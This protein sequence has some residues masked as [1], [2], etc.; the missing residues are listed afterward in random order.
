MY[1]CFNNY[2]ETGVRLILLCV[3][4]YFKNSTTFLPSPSI[5][6]SSNP[7]PSFRMPLYLST[8][9]IPYIP[10]A[11]WKPTFPSGTL[12]PNHHRSFAFR[13]TIFSCSIYL[14]HLPIPFHF[15]L[16]GF[17]FRIIP[18]C[19]FNIPIS[20]FHFLKKDFDFS[21]SNI[22]FFKTKKPIHIN[23]ISFTSLSFLVFHLLCD[24]T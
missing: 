22:Y 15:Y 6:S 3:T 10:F 17:S 8:S 14:R 18:I 2:F 19:T 13:C 20:C 23:W 1:Q 5:P 24:Q 12:I 7:F 11:F 16:S 21:Q 4:H 9:Q